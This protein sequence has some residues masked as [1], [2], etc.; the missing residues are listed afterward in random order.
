MQVA[1]AFRLLRLL[2]GFAK[3]GRSIAARI[4]MMAI[5]TSNSIKVKLG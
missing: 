1:Q 4:A 5:T 3:R 2:F